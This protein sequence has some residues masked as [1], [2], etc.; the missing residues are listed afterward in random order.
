MVLQKRAKIITAVLLFCILAVLGTA[1]EHFERDAF[2]METSVE[3]PA[4][5]Y[6]SDSASVIDGKININSADEEELVQLYGIGNALAERITEYRS[7]NGEFS[8]IEEIMKV[9]GISR[10]KFEAI[11]DNICAE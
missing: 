10:K 9:S 11:K 7:K 1:A 5:D 8:S 2:I 3:E 6:Q 4:F